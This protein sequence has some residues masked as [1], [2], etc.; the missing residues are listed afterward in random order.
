MCMDSNNSTQGLLRKSSKTEDVI[1]AL[2]DANV[3]IGFIVI[4]ESYA[5][6]GEIFREILGQGL[7]N[8]MHVVVIRIF[9]RIFQ[10]LEGKQRARH[11]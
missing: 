3:D 6:N 8:R 10:D 11:S 9:S 2:V 4:T 1:F 5:L 7:S